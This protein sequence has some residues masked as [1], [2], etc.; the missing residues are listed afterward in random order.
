MSWTI[1]F[2]EKATD[3]FNDLDRAVQV[4]ITKYL[5]KI[6]AIENPR[7]FGEPLSHNYSGFWRYS[8]GNYRVI[9]DILENELIVEV[10]N[11]GHRKQVYE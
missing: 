11:V 3:Q 2:N 9:C 6:S 1:R 5:K 8:V 4:R 7:W 10:I